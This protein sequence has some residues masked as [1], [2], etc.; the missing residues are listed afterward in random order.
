MTLADL[1]R[2]FFAHIAQVGERDP[3]IEREV[4]SHGA[5]SAKERL[6]L[7]AQMYFVR[8]LEA[9]GDDFPHTAQL[10]GEQFESLVADYVRAHPS[11]HPSLSEFGRRFPAFLAETELPRPDIAE[12][13]QLEWAR[14]E[15]LTAAEAD[16]VG[17]NVLAALGPEA[18][19]SAAL[20][21]TPSVRVRSFAH[22]V[23]AVWKA[24]ENEEAPPAPNP[25]PSHV[26]VWRGTSVQPERSSDGA[27]SKA[28]KA[29]GPESRLERPSLYRLSVPSA[30]MPRFEVLH[31]EISGEEADALRKVQQG[32]PLAEVCEAFATLADPATAAF[33]AIGSWFAEGMIAAA[34]AP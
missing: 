29:G 33:Q 27:E 18:F 13:A 5:L 15:A 8:L 12:L 26:V 3:A 9:L 17:Q 20:L 23:P 19:G 6:D 28:Q 24:L 10:C 34:I 11:T 22:E 4:R 1:Q 31:A 7:Y 2:A 16:P 32:L 30:A 25:T 14:V 21:L